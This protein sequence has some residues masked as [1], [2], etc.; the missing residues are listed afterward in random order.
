MDESIDLNSND[1]RMAI[2]LEN[3]Q[4]RENAI[5]AV[6]CRE[7]MMRYSCAMK[8]VRTRFEILNAEHSVSS[9]RSPIH[10]ISTRLKGA[11]SIVDKLNRKDLA[12]SARNIE[13]HIND[14]AGVR[15]I[16]PYIDDI[17]ALADQISHQDGIKLLDCKDY[18]TNP[19]ANGYRSLHLI[20]SVPVCFS[21]HTKPVKVEVQIRTIAMDFWAS[22]EHQLK[23]KQRLRNEEELIADLKDCA[24]TIADTERKM[25]K[26]R[27]QIE[28]ENPASKD[29]LLLEK[30]K[31][32]DRPLE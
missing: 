8:E 10:S 32:F 25:L 21:N 20:L 31:K 9:Q 23:Y 15:I 27:L 12:F 13:E 29:E 17:F 19:K 14:V 18:I 26:L 28:G 6:E 22:L 5:V 2:C 16:C 7:L 11:S 24:D 30:L 3:N 4:V 1:T